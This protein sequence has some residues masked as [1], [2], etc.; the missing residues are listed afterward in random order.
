MPRRR[1][2]GTGRTRSR[3]PPSAGSPAPRQPPPGGAGSVRGATSTSSSV[4]TS[5]R[6]HM[7]IAVLSTHGMHAHRVP[8]GAGQHVAVAL[9][10]AGEPVAGHRVVVHVA[11]DQV[12]AVLGAGV[13]DATR[14]RTVP[15]SACRRADPAGRGRPSARCRSHRRGCRARVGHGSLRFVRSW[16]CTVVTIGRC[17][18]TETRS[19]AQHILDGMRATGIRQLFCLP[20]VQNDPFFDAVVDARDWL[21]V[22]VTRHEQ[23]CAY[24]AMGAAQATGRPTAMC[25]VPGPRPAQRIGRIVERVRRRRARC[26]QSSGR[27]TRRCS[28]RDSECSTSSTTSRPCCVRSR[29]TLRSFATSRH[30]A[31]AD[32]GR[33]R[34]IGLRHTTA[35]RH[36]GARRPVGQ[37]GAGRGRGRRS[38]DADDRLAAVDAA[39]ERAARG[40]QPA[41]LG[42]YRRSGCFTCG[43]SAR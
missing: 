15:S 24:M 20:G 33:V 5:K 28:A 35:R 21:E 42:R 32:P 17:P 27:S 41:D 36:R 34:R 12:V 6:S 39:A 10:V 18:E 29:S 37:A 22:I 31:A 2:P 14:G 43:S 40:V 4:S 7:I 19:I 16:R 11:G 23:G 38:N 1:C 26:W 9:L 13:G 25:V 3:W 30:A 8:V